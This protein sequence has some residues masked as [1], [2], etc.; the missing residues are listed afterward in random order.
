MAGTGLKKDDALLAKEGAIFKGDVIDFA[1]NR[2]TKS[3]EDLEKERQ[4]RNDLRVR[5]KSRS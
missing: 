4:R 3:A 5:G 1:D 2:T